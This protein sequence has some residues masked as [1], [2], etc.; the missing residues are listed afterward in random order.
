M[1][2]ANEPVSARKSLVVILGATGS[3][4]SDLALA[5]AE[6]WRGE[7]VNCDSVQVYTGFDIGSAKLP[8]TRRN[9]IPHHLID[10]AGPDDN[11]TAGDYSRQ[12]RRVLAGIS[13]RGNLPV[14]CGGTGFYLRA[15]LSGLSPAPVRCDRLRA[16]LS[17]VAR[18]R[19]LSLH[20]LLER[21]DHIAASRI[22]P[23]DHQ[24]LIRAIEMAYL[25]NAAASAVQARPRDALEG[26]RFLKIGLNPDRG[27]LYS[28]LDARSEEMFHKGLV[29]ETRRLLEQGF[30]ATSKPMQSLGYRQALAVISGSATVESAIRDCQTRTRQYAKRQMTWFRAESNV[31]WLHG[32]GS[33][34]AIAREAFRQVE[35]LHAS[36]SGA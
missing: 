15:L 26:Y 29:E 21:C 32:F 20:C 28:R 11:F 16:R 6:R 27:L 17:K 35:L 8:A 10:V 12:A 2:T 4:K 33:D 3:G 24:K 36:D 5:L 18:L 9:G 7:I 34:P 14:V 13:S 25:E 19:P 31:H 30:T 1:L 23:N 22:H